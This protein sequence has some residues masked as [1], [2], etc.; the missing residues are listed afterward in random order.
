MLI[1]II[2]EYNPFHLGH[3]AQLAAL[4]QAHPDARIVVAV[5]G[6]FVQRGLPA[7]IDK[8]TRAAWAVRA[9]ADLVIELPVLSVLRSAEHFA[10]GGVR[11]LLALGIDILACGMEDPADI[12]LLRLAPS[13]ERIR[14]HLAAGCTY[15]EARTRALAELDPRAAALSRRPNNLLAGYYLRTLAAASA[16]VSVLPLP[17]TTTHTAAARL[18]LP[19]PDED[20]PVSATA[21]R[22]ALAQGQLLRDLL[23]A[24]V[25]RTLADS[26]HR[27]DLRRYELLALADLR[28]FTPSLAATRADFSEGL[29]HRWYAARHAN[30]LP[31][32]WDAVR[33]KRIPLSRLR[34]LTAQLLLGFAADDLARHDAAGAAWIRPL[35]MTSA[36]AGILRRAAVPVIAKTADAPALL[37]P[38]T[39]RRFAYDLTATDLAALTAIDETARTGGQDYTRHP[40][41]VK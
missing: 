30:T 13:D 31:A 5:S 14:A 24:D 9:G 18:S 34:R 15:G 38:D 28:R 1:G 27:T 40:V 25:A 26:P 41:I 37:A 8:W 17:R 4:R 32:F 21:V 6:S 12:D 29:E 39:L 36:G 35:A 7:A 3:A 11:L 23:P 20:L 33:T 2:A 16:D 19:L 10:A 22:T